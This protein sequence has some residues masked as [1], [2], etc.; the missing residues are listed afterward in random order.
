MT[1][2]SGY[3]NFKISAILIPLFLFIPRY[4]SLRLALLALQLEVQ[5]ALQ[6]APFRLLCE[7]L[8]D[9]LR[10]PGQKAGKSW[11]LILCK[12]WK[13]IREELALQKQNGG[14]TTRRSQTVLS[15]TSG[16]LIASHIGKS[17]ISL[18]ILIFLWSDPDW[19]SWLIP[20]DFCSYLKKNHV[21]T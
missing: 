7:F 6:S 21:V 3:S 9:P 8:H 18:L 11:N 16:A 12:V 2:P 1:G 20:C 4:C 17:L 13:F 19:W 15:D 10:Q 5:L 14:L